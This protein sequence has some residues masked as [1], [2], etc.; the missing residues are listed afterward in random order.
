MIFRVFLFLGTRED[1][2]RYGKGESESRRIVQES[3][4]VNWLMVDS[5]SRKESCRLER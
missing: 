5:M 2:E 4:M 1:G 3:C